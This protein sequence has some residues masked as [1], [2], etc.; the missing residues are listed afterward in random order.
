V[1]LA[2]VITWLCKLTG[3]K[4]TVSVFQNQFSEELLPPGYRLSII[5]YSKNTG[6]SRT[7]LQLLKRSR[8]L[9]EIDCGRIERILDFLETELADADYFKNLTLARETYCTTSS[10]Q[11]NT[12]RWIENLVNASID[13]AKILLALEKQHIPQTYK[14]TLLRLSVLPPFSEELTGSLSDYVRLRNILAHEYLD[15]KFPHV[16]AFTAHAVP[17]YRQLADQATC[18]ISTSSANNPY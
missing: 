11:R 4:Q 3:A 10:V 5:I 2:G 17:L 9:S 1:A 7:I 8:S 14:E 6:T 12:E 18:F 15:V 13:I 16:L